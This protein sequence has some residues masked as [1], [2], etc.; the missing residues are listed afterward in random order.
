MKLPDFEAWAVFAAVVEHRSFSAAADALAVS[1]ATVSKAIT[2]L[3]GRLGTTLFHRTSRRLTLTDSGRGLAEHAQRILSEGQAAEEAAFESAS[4]PAGLVRVAAPLTFGILSVAPVLADFMKLYPGIKVELRLSDAFVDIVGE[5]IDVA[6]RIAELPD[7]SLRARRI[8]PV[9][10]HIVGSPEYFDKA[11]R[12]RHP[13]DLAHHA[14]FV[15]TNTANP[16]VWRFRKAGGEE[17]AVRV[18]GPIRTDSGDAMIPALCAG[19]GIAR[20]PDFLISGELAKGKLEAVLED[21]S[22]SAAGLH[23]LTPPGT[24]RPARVEALIEFLSDRLRKTCGE[25]HVRDSTP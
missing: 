14:C 21:W 20:L 1:K 18:D 13:A 2:R 12:P 8:G 6:L 24:L 10:M 23:L 15:Y 16:D 4:A 11:G 17:A 25:F 3:E 19:L 22:V 5:G 9:V 7:S